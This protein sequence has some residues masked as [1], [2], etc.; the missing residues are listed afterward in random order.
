MEAKENC[1]VV[2]EGGH[3][4]GWYHYSHPVTTAAPAAIY[5]KLPSQSC[6]AKS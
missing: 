2:S 4:A 5:P 1:L 3:R 6:C